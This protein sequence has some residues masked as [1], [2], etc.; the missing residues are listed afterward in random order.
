MPA[1]VLMF[2]MGPPISYVSEKQ[3][4]TEAEGQAEDD[5]IVARSVGS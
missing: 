5:E 3:V 2:N 1:R 4:K